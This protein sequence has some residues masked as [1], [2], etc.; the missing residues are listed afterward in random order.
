MNSTLGSV[1]PL[2]M[3]LKRA[4]SN[5]ASGSGKRLFNFRYKAG[6]LRE[7][8]SLCLSST[9]FWW[10]N[11]CGNILCLLLHKLPFRVILLFVSC[12][13]RSL[14]CLYGFGYHTPSC[15]CN[16]RAF[17]RWKSWNHFLLI[18]VCLLVVWIEFNIWIRRLICKTNILSR[19]IDCIREAVKK[20]F[21]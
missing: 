6:I 4:V 13:Q 7:M 16:L 5:R 12:V 19:L 21:F 1:V 8:F 11:I 17:S 10:L 15:A 20:L 14:L 2:A 9:A 3:F 18:S